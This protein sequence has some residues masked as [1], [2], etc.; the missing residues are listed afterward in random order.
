[1]WYQLGRAF[2]IEKKVLEKYSVCSP[3]E[4]II[5]MLDYWLRSHS[6]QPTWKEV[7]EALRKIHLHESAQEIEMIYKTGNV[8][9]LKFNRLYTL[10]F[11]N[12]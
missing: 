12:S 9:L 2:G 11:E 7:A 6:G 10:L 3:E 1:M 5:E 8:S 4:S